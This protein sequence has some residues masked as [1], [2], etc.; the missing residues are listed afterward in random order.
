MRKALI[1]GVTLVI[2][3]IAA[4]LGVSHF[5]GGLVSTQVALYERRLLEIDGVS[6]TRF[7]YERRLFDG[8]LAYD[9]AWRPPLDHPL[10]E[11][12]DEIVKLEG[13]KE[14]RIAGRIPVRHGPW[15]GKF[16][17]ARAEFAAVLPDGARR[18]LPKYPGQ[19]PWLTIDATAEW[20]GEVNATFRLVDYDGRVGEPDDPLEPIAVVDGLHGRAWIA[21][22]ATRATLEAALSRLQG[23][24]V[25]GRAELRDV[26][27][28]GAIDIAA[29][30]RLAGT[31]EIGT[32][33]V[34]GEMP[35]PGGIAAGPFSLT[36]DATREWPFVW[37]G[38][39]VSRLRGLTFD[40]PD[41]RAKFAAFDLRAVTIRKGEK[42]DSTIAIAMGPA[43]IADAGFPAVAFDVSLRDLDGDILNAWTATL[44]SVVAKFDNPDPAAIESLTQLGA[45]LVAARPQFA[46]DRLSLSVRSP[47][48]VKLTLQAQPAAGVEL[49]KDRF[50]PLL[51]WLDTRVNFT[52]SLESIEAFVVALA[53]IDTALEAAV[54]FGPSE[55]QMARERFTRAKEILAHIPIFAIQGDMLSVEAALARGQ[56]SLNGRLT[57]PLQAFAAGAQAIDGMKSAL[58]TATGRDIPDINGMPI[59]TRAISR[60]TLQSGVPQRQHVHAGGNDLMD[61]RLGTDC[62]GYINARR[63]TLA[64]DY[65]AGGEEVF[66]SVTSPYAD[67]ALIVHTPDGTWICNDDDPQRG[68]DPVVRIDQPER[69]RYLVWVATIEAERAEA[70]VQITPTEPARQR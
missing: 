4:Y 19:E 28:M 41:L 29:R 55:E 12:F 63:A 2:A 36:L 64:I 61:G 43:T 7:T 57:D 10:R 31:L 21:P 40:F 24:A 15:I 20:S 44:D 1:G 60:A 14:L 53:R 70:I 65:T 50:A 69:D 32:I 30:H 58:L 35:I 67:T 27:L 26:K 18:Q 68:V 54:V 59:A 33:N 9:I 47:D 48:D 52:A 17:A 51:E 8:D 13:F 62:T 49:P 66:F 42:V 46:I 6:V 22:D 3:A 11:A 34:K 45:K 5:I 56:I 39:F 23:G 25:P 38:D 16:A 37:T